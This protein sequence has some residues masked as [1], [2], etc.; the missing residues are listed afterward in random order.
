MPLVHPS[1][2]TTCVILQDA[3]TG[4]MLPLPA[5][6]AELDAEHTEL[7]RVA[8]H[9]LQVVVLTARVVRGVIS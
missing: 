7:A 9:Q 2:R 8:R 3:C 4:G 6:S 5:V 1:H